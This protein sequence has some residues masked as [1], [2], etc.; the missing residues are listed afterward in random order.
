MTSGYKE[1]ERVLSDIKKN[2]TP[3]S[4]SIIQLSVFSK[5]RGTSH[6]IQNNMHKETMLQKLSYFP[7]SMMSWQFRKRF[8]IVSTLILMGCVLNVT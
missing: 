8:C 4:N 6:L 7:T 3:T 2:E 1:D 5:T